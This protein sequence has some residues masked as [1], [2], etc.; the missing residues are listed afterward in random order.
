MRKAE[1]ELQAVRTSFRFVSDAADLELLLIPLRNT[2]D[3]VEQERPRQTVQRF[4]VLLV[5]D[6]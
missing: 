5:G 6:A 4:V 1:R 3:H 2:L